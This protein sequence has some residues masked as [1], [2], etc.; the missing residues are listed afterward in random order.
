MLW[1]NI[2]NLDARGKE[3][4]LALNNDKRSF[5]L[6]H[7]WQSLKHDC[8]AQEGEKIPWLFHSTPALGETLLLLSLKQCYLLDSLTRWGL[9]P[10]HQL[11][12]DL[13]A[14]WDD[15]WAKKM[16]RHTV[17]LH[18]PVCSTAKYPAALYVPAATANSCCFV[19]VITTHRSPIT[20]DTFADKQ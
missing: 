6:T 16:H 11:S 8:G 3:K 19:H 9:Q 2:Y 1:D 7:L 18:L 10:G 14:P 12:E 4:P 13:S 20:M 5:P 17:H 15:I